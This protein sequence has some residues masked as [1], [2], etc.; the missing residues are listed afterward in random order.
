MLHIPFDKL[1]GRCTK[2]VLA[3]LGDAYNKA[4][5][6]K[7]VSK[8]KSPAGLENAVRPKCDS[9]VFIQKPAIEQIVHR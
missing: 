8:A 7:L 5:I 3:P 1:P 4:D 9:S 2:N 6:L